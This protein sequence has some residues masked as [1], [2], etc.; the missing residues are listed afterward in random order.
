MGRHS[1]LGR[2]SSYCEKLLC[3]FHTSNLWDRPWA[4][5]ITT[6]CKKC[7]LGISGKFARQAMVGRDPRDT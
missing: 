2:L 6:L 7:H 4:L 5:S 1:H 3:P